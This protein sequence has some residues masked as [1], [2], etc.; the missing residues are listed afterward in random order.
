MFTTQ[1]VL[2]FIVLSNLARSLTR[3]S[4][5]L[6]LWFDHSTMD[7]IQKGYCKWDVWSMRSHFLL[8]CFA[9]WILVLLCNYLVM[10][11]LPKMFSLIDLNTLFWLIQPPH[12]HKQSIPSPERFQLA[13]ACGNAGLSSRKLNR[14]QK[15]GIIDSGWHSVKKRCLVLPLLTLQLYCY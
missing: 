12:K 4:F 10:F 3:C 14:I 1:Q 15:R 2:H 7:V 11:L 9:N 13:Q 5:R 8:V 6:L